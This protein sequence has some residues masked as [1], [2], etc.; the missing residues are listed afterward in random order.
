M[1]SVIMLLPRKGRAHY[2]YMIVFDADSVMTG[3]ILV[4]M[5]HIMERRRNVG[6]LQT[7]PACTGRETLIARAQQFAN[8]AYGPMYAAGLHH[9]FLGDAQFW[10]HNAIIRVQPLSSRFAASR[11][12]GATRVWAI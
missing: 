11:T 1:V 7:A 6:I 12:I 4:C 3:E 2:T 8:R 10:G 5:V 9:W